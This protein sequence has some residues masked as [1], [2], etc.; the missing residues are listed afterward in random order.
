M[1]E[2]GAEW[3]ERLAGEAVSLGGAL[4]RRGPERDKLRSCAAGLAAAAAAFRHAR[5]LA[6]AALRAAL[7]PRLHAWALHLAA[8]LPAQAASDADADA[9]IEE[10]EEEAAALPAA[11]EVLASAA[12]EALPGAAEELLTGV[13]GELAA[14]A[15]QAMLRHQYDRVGVEGGVGVRV[16]EGGLGVERRARRMAA[17]AGSA[18]GG[19]RERC[20]RVTQCAALLGLEPV[21]HAADAL[22]P[23][24]RLSP[25]DARDLLARRTDF[26]MEEIKR[27]KL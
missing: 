11:L 1:A 10:L 5:H 9:L 7:Q 15:E 20:A 19:A 6:L 4:C 26:K 23:A 22:Q 14:R 12:R 25:K 17:W 16:R 27:L 18:A 2:C 24:P 3:A 21:S 8:P 13:V